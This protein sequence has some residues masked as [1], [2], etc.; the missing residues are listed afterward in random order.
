MRDRYRELVLEDIATHTGVDL[1]D[2]IRVEETAC[3]SEFAE[4]VNAPAGTALGLAH[5]LGQTGPLRPGHRAP[6]DGSY[7][8]GGYTTP[9]IGMPMCLIS[10]QHTYEAIREDATQQGLR[11]R[12][13]AN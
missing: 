13:F 12:L 3:I 9:G 5:T 7:Y 2:R 8:T 1:R 6:L 10:G 11:R 4:W